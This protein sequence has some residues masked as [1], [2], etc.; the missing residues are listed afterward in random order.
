MCKVK[1]FIY[2][3]DKTGGHHHKQIECRDM[4]VEWHNDPFDYRDFDEA[5]SEYMYHEEQRLEKELDK[6]FGGGYAYSFEW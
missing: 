5:F 2:E 3:L 1:A 4:E 6:E